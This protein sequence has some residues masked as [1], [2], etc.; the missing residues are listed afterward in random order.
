[1]H[2]EFSFL[3]LALLWYEYV[4]YQ[5]HLTKLWSILYFI[6]RSGGEIS[7]TVTGKGGTLYAVSK[8]CYSRQAVLEFPKQEPKKN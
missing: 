5:W 6:K 2:N 3:E 1:M 8:N 7:S 4:T